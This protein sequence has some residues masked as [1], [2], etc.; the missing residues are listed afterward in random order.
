MQK[1]S[2]TTVSG[3]AAHTDTGTAIFPVARPTDVLTIWIGYKNIRTMINLLCASLQTA[4]ELGKLSEIHF[5]CHGHE[6]VRVF[7]IGF[8]SSQ[9]SNQRYAPNSRKPRRRPKEFV[10]RCKEL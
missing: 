9:R 3:I 5:L 6:N 8:Y 2:Q 10:D 1:R 4:A 7:R